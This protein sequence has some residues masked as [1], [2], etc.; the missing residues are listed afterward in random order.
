MYL[1]KIQAD[2][3]SDCEAKCHLKKVFHVDV[4]QHT[5]ADLEKTVC[6][7]AARKLV[8]FSLQQ[9]SNSA[10]TLLARIRSIK[11]LTLKGKGDF[12]EGCHSASTEPYFYEA[13]YQPVQRDTP[14][15]PVNEYGHCI[16][17][18][19]IKWKCSSYIVNANPFLKVR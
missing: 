15:I 12:G 13:A 5:R 3:L 4:F 2:L 1:R 6:K 9:R 16:V 19:K 10:V 8:N 11:S 14:A 18:E 7:L 17:A